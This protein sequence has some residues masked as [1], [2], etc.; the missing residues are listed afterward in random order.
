MDP[1]S[2]QS[3]QAVVLRPTGT[4]DELARVLQ[5]GQVVAGEVLQN[6]DGSVL[7]AIGRHRITAQ[8]QVRLEPGQRFLFEVVESSEGIAL[9]ILDPGAAS[10]EPTLL[11]ALRAVMGRSQP[12]GEIVAELRAALLKAQPTPEPG[13]P[14]ATLLDALARHVWTYADGAEELARLLAQNGTSYEAHL[15]DAALETG[16]PRELERIAQALRAGL[17]AELADDSGVLGRTP[18]E[19]FAKLGEGLWRELART[20]GVDVATARATL[21]AELDWNGLARDL[22]SWLGRA[23]AS[24][25]KD[26]AVAVAHA[27]LQAVD[28]ES[29]TREERLLFARVLLGAPV[30]TEAARDPARIRAR[31]SLLVA[32][33]KSELLI[34]LERTPAGPVRG[35]I[36]R[37]LAALEAEQL[38][39]LARA[40]GGEARHWSLPIAD[41]QRLA[42]LD[43]THH[44]V[45]ERL[46]GGGEGEPSHRLSFA[47]DFT[48]TGPVRADLLARNGQLSVRLSV[49]E[50]AVVAHLRA[51]LHELQTRLSSGGRSV[52]V[53][54]VPA[55]LADVRVRPGPSE[56][57]YLREHH[58]M[59]LQG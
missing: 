32:D 10:D 24:L 54:L 45:E 15:L 49:V 5:R 47:V 42:T 31:V 3:T 12:I 37:T 27:R 46:A 14:V 57:R 7:L 8:S 6:T 50:P 48:H 55:E 13:S 56:I 44:R 53:A 22:K 33:L 36:E 4:G 52:H 11:R 25:G 39:N 9:R 18:D 19:F 23:L 34:A 21:L 35:A 1:L 16:S 40:E 17:F 26:P 20:L 51:D 30:A 38:F 58:V 59:D 2:L 41:G 29:W 28:F 43:L